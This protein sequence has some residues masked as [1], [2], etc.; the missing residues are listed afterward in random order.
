MRRLL[1]FLL[2]FGCP[3]TPKT[4]PPEALS[5]CEGYES[6]AFSIGGVDTGTSPVA[7]IDDS[8]SVNVSY[9]G[10]CEEHLF[11]LC[12]P[13][14]SFME[15]D[16]V[17]VSLQIWHGGEPDMCEA[18]LTD[19]LS[20]DLSPLKAAWKEAYGDG[21]GTIIINLDGAPETVEYSFE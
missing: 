19:T 21:P 14:Q 13:S 6:A 8:L 17:Q 20:F 4:D 12:W 1:P 7:V 9:G 10:G 18:Y 3:I 2:C 5:T 11:T 15:S 16:P